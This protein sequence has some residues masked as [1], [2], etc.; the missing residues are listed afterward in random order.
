MISSFLV[1][2]CANVLA[3][4][5]FL[6]VWKTA[7]SAQWNYYCSFINKVINLVY[8]IFNTALFNGV[9]MLLTLLILLSFT[10]EVTDSWE[11]VDVIYTDFSKAFHVLMSSIGQISN[12]LLHLS[13]LRAN[14]NRCNVVDRILMHSH[15]LLVCRKGQILDLFYKSSLVI[16]W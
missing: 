5:I 7:W 1:K 12:E 3:V 10:V 11:Q 2:E 8:L 6:Y 14:M 13:Y 9:Q 4:Q 16:C 15:F